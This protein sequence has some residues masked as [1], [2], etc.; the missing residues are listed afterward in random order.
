MN[1]PNLAVESGAQL[2]LTGANRLAAL[3]NAGSILI[4]P[5][6]TLDLQSASVAPGASIVLQGND[7]ARLLVNGPTFRNEGTIQGSGLIE[8]GSGLGTFTNGTS[9]LPGAPVASLDPVGSLQLRARSLTLEPN[10]R[11]L[12]D[13][14]TADQLS[15]F[16]DTLLGGGLEV[17]SPPLVGVITPF[18]LIRARSITGAFDPGQIVLPIGFTLEG[19]AMTGDPL[20]PV[21]FGGNLAATPAPPP[22]PPDPPIIPTPPAVPVTPSPPVTPMA[23]QMVTA[24]AAPSPSTPSP[25]T[26]SFLMPDLG[27]R[28]FP[29]TQTTPFGSTLSTTRRGVGSDALAVN[30]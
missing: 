15:V 21:S 22:A 13:L 27:Y 20:L 24:P 11:L 3:A 12:F 26:P 9:L 6:S 19:V 4:A 10:S 25:S 1:G 16:G 8:V 30:L 29:S 23:P 18:D 17:V 7:S 5:G 14:S 28:I 2:Q